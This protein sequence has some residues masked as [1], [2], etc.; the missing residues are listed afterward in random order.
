MHAGR[1]RYK[2]SVSFVVHSGRVHSDA[3]EYRISGM[4]FGD[5]FL[6]GF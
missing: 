4:G 5:S 3:V 6:L 1:V 2:A